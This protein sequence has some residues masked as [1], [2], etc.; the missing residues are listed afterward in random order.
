[1][2]RGSYIGLVGTLALTGLF[3]T[4]PTTRALSDNCRHINGHIAGQV[5]GPSPLCGG[6]LT[7][8]GTFT[9]GYGNTL[10]TFVACATGLEQEGNGAQK[11]H[12]VHTYTTNG[13]DTFTTSDDIVLSPTDPPLYGVNNR[14]LVTGGTGIY[15]NAIGFINDHGSF[16]FQTGEVSVD[17]H[18]QIC[19]PQQARYSD[20]LGR[21]SPWTKG[22]PVI[23]DQEL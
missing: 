5:I 15:E 9:D 18:G 1:M 12:L 10:G 11:L 8:I 6:A 20:P 13:G 19:T 2:K 14:A 21:R 17:Y 3:L 4:T 22:H 7:E 23:L 16:S